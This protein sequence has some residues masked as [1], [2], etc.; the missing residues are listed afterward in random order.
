MLRGN[1]P[2]Q[3]AFLTELSTLRYFTFSKCHADNFIRQSVIQ[4]RACS[5]IPCANPH[6]TLHKSP[7]VSAVL[8]MKEVTLGVCQDHSREQ[9]QKVCWFQELS[10]VDPSSWSDFSL[11]RAIANFKLVKIVSLKISRVKTFRQCNLYREMTAY[12][13]RNRKP[14]RFI[15]SVN[16]H[17][18]QVHVRRK[19]KVWQYLQFSCVSRELRSTSRCNIANFYTSGLHPD[20]TKDS[21]EKKNNNKKPT[22]CVYY[23]N[24]KSLSQNVLVFSPATGGSLFLRHHCYK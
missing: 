10:L 12:L 7:L 15:F 1:V 11:F 24:A 22:R 9:T 19:K 17:F 6:V 4:R 2:R 23:T 8:C 5:G 14:L 18:S 3:L 20:G 13:T 21:E 16:Q